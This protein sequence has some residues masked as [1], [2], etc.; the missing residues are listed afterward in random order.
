MTRTWIQSRLTGSQ[1][2]ILLLDVVGFGLRNQSAAEMPEDGHGLVQLFNYMYRAFSLAL[3]LQCQVLCLK[4]LVIDFQL[5][6]E[7]ARMASQPT[8]SA[9]LFA[10]RLSLS[11]ADPER[12]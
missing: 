4:E 12:C 10:E 5:S 3:R 9:F 7:A 8:R 6:I 2:V 11:I 1:L